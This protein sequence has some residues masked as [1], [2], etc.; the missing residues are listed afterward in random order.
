MS[1]SSSYSDSDE[2]TDHSKQRKRKLNG[3][4]TKQLNAAVN[5]LPS[6]AIRKKP[7]GIKQ[8]K[9]V[10][11]SSESSSSEEEQ[12]ELP[13]TRRY[14]RKRILPNIP[15]KRAKKDSDSEWESENE[16]D[17]LP[18]KKLHPMKKK[19]TKK[20]DKPPNP[21]TKDERRTELLFSNHLLAEE[22]QAYLLDA[23]STQDSSWTATEQ[24]YLQTWASRVQKALD[25]QNQVL[26]ENIDL[27][28]HLRKVSRRRN[29]LQD[30]LLV[31]K[32]TIQA[33]QQTIQATQGQVQEAKQQ[34]TQAQS[35]NRFLLSLRTLAR[36]GS[37]KK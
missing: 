18:E 31:Q 16:E 8:Q 37:G 30:K 26:L 32:K 3:N 19:P 14:G 1:S 24:E 27:V 10:E 23:T 25:Q 7:K 20:N 2:S 28:H 22:I 21:N 12:K 35:A 17:T 29:Q 36:G 15:S 11:S 9:P 33:T 4:P 34:E 6:M 5:M 13:A